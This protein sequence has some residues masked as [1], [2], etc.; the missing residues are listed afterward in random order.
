MGKRDS[1]P[2]SRIPV[3]NC[4][5]IEQSRKS[6]LAEYATNCYGQDPLM[7]GKMSEN[8]C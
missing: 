5:R 1:L 4:G 3:N 7:D 6:A 2:Y 8:L